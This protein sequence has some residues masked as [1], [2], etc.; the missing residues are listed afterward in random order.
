[1]AK[2]GMT[3]ASD[4][5]R[6]EVEAPWPA[7]SRGWWAV[8][9]FCV[10]AI[11]SYSD[12]Q[13]LSLLV[14]P[15]RA[16][17]HATDVQISLLQG[18]A[19]ALIYAVAGVALGRAADVLSR[20]L[21]IV[22]GVLVWSLATIACGYAGQFWTLFGARALVGVGEAALAPA[23][24]SIITD[25]FPAN[26]RGA[27]VGALLMGMVIGSGVALAVGGFI[28]QAAQHGALQ[29][30]PILGA[31]APWRAGLVALGLS[32]LPVA[33]LAA[34]VA[35]PARRHLTLGAKGGASL[36]QAAGGLW[37]LR[38]PLWPL[39]AAMG[40]ASL[41]DFAILNWVPTLLARRYGV[42]VGQIGAVFGGV[43]SLGG[44]LGSFGAGLV[45][46][47]LVTRSGSPARLKLAV[48]AMVLGIAGALMILAPG[49][50][51]IFALTGLWMFAST[52]GQ[53]LGITVVQ[54]VVPGE[55]RGL[56]MSL[57]SLINVG[58]GLALGAYLPAMI[59]E[60]GLHDP[61]AV[62]PAITAVAL[63]CAIVST[64]LYGMALTRLRKAGLP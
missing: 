58:V 35:E 37:A 64:A 42:D 20:R 54:E 59:L 15:I 34:T 52:T 38:Q 25:S 41:T 45:A 63:P 21:V 51:A 28:L 19:F 11:L 60:H 10:A 57:V 7:A 32:G 4:P 23:A 48:G 29:G 55:A 14:D 27:G 5:A 3:T 22:T 12:R 36:A 17:L 50:G 49:P 43:L 30:V 56:C 47:R 26:R 1:M 16:D 46:D 9:V 6:A 8:G 24:M 39:F 62:A 53:S 61:K 31:L 33:L 44:V 2:S 13:I 40:L 18:A